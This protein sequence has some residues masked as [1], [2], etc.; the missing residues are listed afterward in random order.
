LASRFHFPF[1]EQGRG[2]SSPLTPGE[3]ACPHLSLVADL[4]T[5]YGSLSA[6]MQLDCITLEGHRDAHRAEP[7]HGMGIFPGIL[8][9]F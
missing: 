2:P 9:L 7:H 5:P 6:A 8:G 4:L 1:L 3:A